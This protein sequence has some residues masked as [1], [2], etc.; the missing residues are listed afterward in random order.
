M[1]R[2]NAI[3]PQKGRTR[4]SQSEQLEP[5]ALFPPE[6][7]RGYAIAAAVSVFV[8]MGYLLRIDRVIGLM[9][10]DGWYV[11]LAKSLATGQGYQLINSPSQGILP[12]YPPLFPFLLSIAYRIWPV[13]PENIYILKSVSIT[14]MMISG[15]LVY[16]HFVRDRAV[17][18]VF[19]LALGLATATSPAFVFLATS[20]VMSECTYLCLQLAAMVV[21]DRVRTVG[22]PGSWRFWTTMGQKR[23]WRGWQYTLGAAALASGSFLTR[24][25][26]I[27]V[28][29]AIGIYLIKSRLF[30]LA[31]V[32]T[33]GVIIFAGPWILYQQTH[34]PT[35]EQRI[36]QNSYIIQGY[37]SQMSD[38]GLEEGV[39][40]GHFERVFFNLSFFVEH[41]TGALVLYPWFRAAEPAIGQGRTPVKALVSLVLLLITMIGMIQAWRARVTSGD[42]VFMLTV[43]LSIIWIYFSFR[44]FIPL[45][46]WI[47]YYFGLGVRV[48]ARSFRF[49]RQRA[50]ELDWGWA[51]GAV[52]LIVA[53]N[54]FGNLDYILQHHGLAGDR[55]VWVRNFEEN[56][57]TVRWVDQNLPKD[58]VLTS[59]N[60]SLLYLYTGRKTVGNTNPA[61][62]WELWKRMGIRYGVWLKYSALTDPSEAEKRFAIPFQ[63][64]RLKLRV[65]DFGEA[66]AR[67]DWGSH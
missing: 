44:L 16:L 6:K 32:F 42:L 41:H 34:L 50:V 31:A 10:D 11:V 30:S 39:K 17:N 48:V 24:S 38:I 46:P 7:Q 52:W 40:I 2:K 13:F 25:I 20:T 64:D 12:V 35:A 58:A 26:G 1:K 37:G 59:S 65:V 49:S 33:L 45:A 62:N 28:I 60:P 53:I 47:F 63:S 14:A 27:V 29:G 67:P 23:Y 56:E 5:V 36:E 3:Q 51:A 66:D 19:G 8:L 18:R 9:V 4:R 15:W 54:S 61:V 22:E 43:G 57:E 55:P 21:I